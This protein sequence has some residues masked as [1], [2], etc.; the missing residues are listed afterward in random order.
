MGTTSATVRLHCPSMNSLPFRMKG[1][2]GLPAI[3]LMTT[4]TTITTG[5]RAPGCN[6]QNPTP[7]GLPATGAITATATSTTKAI[8]DR[9]S[10][11]TAASITGT[12]TTEKAIRVDVGITDASITTG[13]A[14]TSATFVT[15]M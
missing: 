7:T 15:Y 2:S 14:I 5:S 3:G 6:R 13:I 10:A 8:G 1:T 9:K 4:I 12:A 11:T